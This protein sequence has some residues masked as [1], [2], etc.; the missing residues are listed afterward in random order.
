MNVR[1]RSAVIIA[2]IVALDRVT[3]LYIR[4]ARVAM[5]YVRGNPDVLQHRPYREPRCGVRHA[6]RL[7]QPVAGY[8]AGGRFTGGDDGDRHYALA[9]SAFGFSFAP[10]GAGAGLSERALATSGDCGCSRARGTVTDFL[11]FFFGPYEFPAFN[12][13]GRQRHHHRGGIAAAG[14]VEYAPFTRVA[15]IL[16]NMRLMLSLMLMVGSLSAEGIARDE[17][18]LRRADLRK[19]LDGNLV[20]F[21]PRNELG[22]PA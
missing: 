17:Y 8:P 5:G 7:A 14:F 11:Q 4:S 6:F 1:L 16:V 18:R 12:Q 15:G 2:A 20:L 19:S 21:A 13:C 10:L 9:S 22:R 3:K